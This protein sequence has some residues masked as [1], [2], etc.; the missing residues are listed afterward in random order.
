MRSIHILHPLNW[1]SDAE[2]MAGEASHQTHT[3]V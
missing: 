2:E 1:G 3:N